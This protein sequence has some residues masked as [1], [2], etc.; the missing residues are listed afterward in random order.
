MDQILPRAVTKKN[1]AGNTMWKKVKLQIEGVNQTLRATLKKNARSK[2]KWFQ[3]VT[4]KSTTEKQ[5]NNWPTTLCETEYYLL[6]K[7]TGFVQIGTQGLCCSRHN[8]NLQVK[9]ARNANKFEYI[10]KQSTTRDEFRRL[11]VSC[12]QSY[13]RGKSLLRGCNTLAY[14]KGN[15]RKDNK[16]SSEKKM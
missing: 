11:D 16:G 8:R 3:D 12:E 14:R 13:L 5:T 10:M 4:T 6:E 15:Y 9:L 7:K 2:K 1:K